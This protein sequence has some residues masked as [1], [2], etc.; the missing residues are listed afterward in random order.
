MSLP[1]SL[2]NWQ[3]R[4]APAGL[5]L[6][7]LGYAPSKALANFGLG[8]LLMAFLMRIRHEWHWLRNDPLVRLSGLWLATLVILATRA[9]LSRPET[10]SYQFNSILEMFSFGLIPLVAWATKGDARRIAITLGLALAGL[11]L[12]LL[13]EANWL[14]EGPLFDYAIKAFGIGK[15][16]A[17]VMLDAGIAGT[18]LLL[19]YQLSRFDKAKGAE[20]LIPIPLVAILILLLAAW[21][22]IPSRATW[23]SLG[24]S[25][26]LITVMLLLHSARGHLSRAGV[27]LI[28]LTLV[29]AGTWVTLYFGDRMSPKLFSEQETWRILLEG[30]WDRVPHT[31]V[32]LRFHMWTF[33]LET[34][35]SHPILG[36][37]LSV[38]DLLLRNELPY[39]RPF[40]QFHSGYVEL[41]LRTGL[42]G[43]AFYITALLLI[44]ST[45]KRGLAEGRVHFLLFLFLLDAFLIFALNN[46]S[47]TF[48]FFQHGWQY[49]VLFGGIA[50]GFRW[51]DRATPCN[52]S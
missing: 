41:L 8:I 5:Y 27:A 43:I 23:I 28:L 19:V 38:G 26:S 52:A 49:I 34:W 29:V 6:F 25:L 45:L 17:G 51:H 46:V 10:A 11:I 31:S 47:N 50:Y 3:S 37:G 1:P 48:I 35:L 12:R 9:S 33:A 20:R 2:T 39:L 36:V 13:W 16:A 7:A 4:L 24:A 18:I 40:N 42:V 32:G 44:Y 30:A 15:N 14:S 22:S 21:A